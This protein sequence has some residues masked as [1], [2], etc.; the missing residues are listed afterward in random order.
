MFHFIKTA[1]NNRPERTWPWH[2]YAMILLMVSLATVAE[3][4]QGQVIPTKFG[5]GHGQ[6]AFI[7]RSMVV[8][9]KIR[10]PDGPTRPVPAGS[11]VKIIH[12]KGVEGLNG[13][14]VPADME[15]QVSAYD[16][17]GEFA[18][19]EDDFVVLTSDLTACLT[20]LQD[21]SEFTRQFATGNY[22]SLIEWER[23]WNSYARAIEIDPSNSFA[24]LAL[25]LA[26][27]TPERKVKRLEL[28]GKEVPSCHW[29]AQTEIAKLAGDF[30]RLEAIGK[31]AEAP[32]LVY[33]EML[34]YLLTPGNIPKSQDPFKDPV[35]KAHQYGFSSR[36]MTQ[37]ASMLRLV[38]VEPDMG[39]QER[40]SGILLYC[41][42]ALRMDPWFYHALLVRSDLYAM[43]RR[44]LPAA[45]DI[46][47]ALKLNPLAL[48][49]MSQYLDRMESAE[50]VN[51]LADKDD[52]SLDLLRRHNISK[53]LNQLSRT[54]NSDIPLTNGVN[55]ELFLHGYCAVNFGES[56]PVKTKLLMERDGKEALSYLQETFNLD[57]AALGLDQ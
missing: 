4:A 6:R 7:T 36:M 15:G 53:L 11:V 49:A 38:H 50:V 33:V 44:H 46:N 31:E 42:L 22:Y 27:P 56:Q 3:I 1:R 26:Q 55:L 37:M 54:R 5:Q 8:P 19:T 41:E 43:G 2:R 34:E 23:A 52:E 29:R 48:K 21:Q 35:E 25:A 9:L 45:R 13:V 40:I 47:Q 39:L 14:E 18:L 24:Q 28:I 17:F 51:A 16:D 30:K 12:V 20:A 57:P 10:D 32:Q